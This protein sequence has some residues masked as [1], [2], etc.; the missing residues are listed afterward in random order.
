[1]L[2]GAVVMPHAAEAA[3]VALST[4]NL[5][6]TLHPAGGGASS[7]GK[8]VEVALD[9]AWVAN[10]TA[11]D[12]AKWISYAQTG[13]GG[14][15]PENGTTVAM[16][17]RFRT[18]DG[19]LLT[20]SLYVDDTVQVLLDGVLLDTTRSYQPSWYGG[21]DGSYQ[22][23]LA[24]G[25]HELTVMFTQTAGGPT[26]VQYRFDATSVVTPIPGALPLAATALVGM[27]G[28]GWLKRR[29]QKAAA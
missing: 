15:S 27:G 3:V 6:Y 25:L 20:G 12:G 13:Q 10:G 26:G 4:G 14:F 29:S 17:S 21:H 16:S 23:S 9:G 24:A 22:A 8:T 7:T 19:G 11:G 2:L 5:D 28:L 18:G 1:M